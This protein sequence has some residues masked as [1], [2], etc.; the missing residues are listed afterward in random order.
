MWCAT[1]AAGNSSQ[2]AGSATIHNRRAFRPAF[3]C[4]RGR[5]TRFH[6]YA[7][8]SKGES[9]NDRVLIKF[10][11]ST[12]VPVEATTTSLSD[13]IMAAR[14]R[15]PWNVDVFLSGSVWF[16]SWFLIPAVSCRGPIVVGDPYST[17]F[18]GQGLRSKYRRRPLGGI[19]KFQT[20]IDGRG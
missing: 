19:M 6:T 7:A 20:P 3:L 2:P 5:L 11:R 8:F 15:V 12:T 9:T 13:C 17:L 4:E 16:G 1:C 18:I 14:I 10:D